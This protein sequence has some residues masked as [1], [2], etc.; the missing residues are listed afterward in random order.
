MGLRAVERLPLALSLGRR[1][2]LE[3]GQAAALLLD[4]LLTWRWEEERQRWFYNKDK[5]RAV[6]GPTR[7]SEQRST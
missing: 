4:H 3:L 6:E 2:L 5:D 1:P 7:C